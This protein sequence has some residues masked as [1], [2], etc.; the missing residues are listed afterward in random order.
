M[1]LR[2]IRIVPSVILLVIRVLIISAVLKNNN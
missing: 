2:M 1:L